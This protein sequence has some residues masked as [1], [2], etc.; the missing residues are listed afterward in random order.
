MFPRLIFI[1]I[2]FLSAFHFRVVSIKNK[3]NEIRNIKTKYISPDT[4]VS[5]L[6]KHPVYEIYTSVYS[7][8]SKYQ[9]LSL[10]FYPLF[11]GG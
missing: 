2:P 6:V 10:K 11:R 9:T 5:S 3:I 8:T 1:I 4:Q 7:K